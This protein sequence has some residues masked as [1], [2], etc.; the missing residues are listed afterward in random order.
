MT[1][2]ELKKEANIYRGALLTEALIPGR[3]LRAVA[4]FLRM[5]AALLFAGWLVLFFA[6][7]IPSFAAFFP[8]FEAFALF[9]FPPFTSAF[10]LMLGLWLVFALWYGYFTSFYF[11]D[12]DTVL[13]EFTMR[14]PS[15]RFETAQ[16]ATAGFGEPV[17][18][19][20]VSRFGAEVLLRLGLPRED[21]LAF[22]KERKPPANVFEIAVADNEPV[23]LPEIAA[24]LL[25]YDEALQHFLVSRKIG[26]PDFIGAAEWV[27]RIEAARKKRMRWWS[28]DA[29]GRIPGIGKDWAYGE[30]ML[31]SRY[32]I[33]I[34]LHPAY[35]LAGKG[36]LGTRETKEVERIL[37]RGRESNVILVGEEGAPKLAPLVRLSREISAGTILPPLEHKRIF[38]FNG[39]PFVA[40]MKEKA[41]F[42]TELM[43]LMSEA[44]KAGNIIFVF[45]N[46]EK[47]CQGA[48]ALG[49]DALSLLDPFLISSNIQIVA[50]TELGAFHQMFESNAKVQERFERVLMSEAGITGSLPV[51]ED[52]ALRAERAAGVL[53]TYQALR[54]TAES[55]ERY[56]FEGVMP[57]KAIDLLLEL[58]PKVKAA[59]KRVIVKEDVLELVSAKTGIAVSEATGEERA[60]L[61]RLEEILHERIV[62]QDEAVKAISGALRRARS[63]VSSEKR[64]IGSF[65]FL[66]PTGVG[67]TE[68]T[69]ALAQAFFG[70]E[71]SIARLDM[72]EYQSG[73]AL[74][75]LIGAFE[76]GKAGVLASLLRERPYGV[77]L[78]D[79]FEKTSR[80]VHDLFLQILDEGFFTDVFGKRVNARNLIII[81]TSNAG[82]DLIWK[83]EQEGKSL[84]K[85]IVLTEIISR[86]I[87]KPE[88][89]NRFD[90]VILFHPLRGE[91]LKAIAKLQLQKLGKRLKEKGL[92]LSI[93]EP[94]VEYLV[95]VG[96]D[97]KFGARPMNRAIQEK[98]EQAIAEKMLRGEIEAGSRVELSA[99]DLSSNGLDSRFRENAQKS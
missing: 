47:F 43:R 70:D 6:P 96:Q 27:S 26:A 88:L 39:A 66:G 31:L 92:E 37:S 4:G 94:L 82:S 12:D 20:F 35:A 8:K 13:P 73:D 52:E 59:G 34:A 91:H 21:V 40:A 62:G 65:L 24:A 81:A 84:S 1:Y 25:R 77:L 89:L 38:I 63:G 69:K 49:S 54:A 78:L 46:F 18:D 97:P 86:A 56:F 57:D 29:L 48:S 32:A 67:K 17:V 76:S 72:S 11:K 44:T 83:A 80:E 14:P 68:T 98:V 64:P 61:L 23:G 55:A 10:L 74:A 2:Q 85:D 50:I 60:K 36:A 15:I 41:I 28:K 30:I 5:F 58:V 95:S 71:N 3:R 22:L 16:L 7:A 90:G 33:P 42:E 45:D 75:R 53:F 87:F 9:W 93:T 79:E 99:A 19:F 51:L